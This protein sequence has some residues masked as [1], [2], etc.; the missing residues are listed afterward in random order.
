MFQKILSEMRDRVRA[1]Q[2]AMSIHAIE[3]MQLDGL[4]LDDLKQ[5]ILTGRIVERQFDEL[6]AENKYLIESATLDSA[7]FIH[8][9]AKLGKK[10][11]VIITMYRV[12]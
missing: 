11:T 12:W 7:E 1:G 4:T 10:N 6:F 3:E 8:V 9:V 2:V 5:C